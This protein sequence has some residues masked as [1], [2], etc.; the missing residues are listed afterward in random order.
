MKTLTT[1]AL[2]C[3]I[4]SACKKDSKPTGVQVQVSDLP[5]GVTLSIKVNDGGNNIILEKDNTSEN[6]TYTTSAV[7]PGDRLIISYDLSK[8]LPTDVTLKFFYKGEGMGSASFPYSG[9]IQESVPM[10]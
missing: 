7:N 9:E 5:S 3:L 2:L 4:F 6:T 1:L 8:Q 10:P